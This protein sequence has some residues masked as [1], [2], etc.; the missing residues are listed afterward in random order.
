MCL[1]QFERKQPKAFWKKFDAKKI[2]YAEMNGR[3]IRV[4]EF[5]FILDVIFG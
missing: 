5:T 1:K 4:A 2:S 3:N